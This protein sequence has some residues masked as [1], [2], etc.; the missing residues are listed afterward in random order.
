VFG[1]PVAREDD[2]L[3]AARAAL[4]LREELTALSDELDVELGIRIELHQ[5]LE[6][7]EVV[8]A[9]P[10]RRGALVTGD[11]VGLA[12][13]LQGSAAPGEIV[14]GPLAAS[15]I[16]HAGELEP[17]GELAVRGRREPV[18]ASRL[19]ALADAA[20]A[21]PRR[22]DVPLVGRRAELGALRE[23]LRVAVGGPSVEA[24]AVVGPAGIGKSRL[25]RELAAAAEDVAA[26]AARC[27]SHGKGMTYWPLRTLIEAA[28]SS[29]DR[30]AIAAVAD[31]STADV[32]AAAL[33]QDEAA[34]NTREVPWAFRRFCEALA[35]R[36]PVLLV[37]D[38]LHWAEPAFRDVVER[39]VEPGDAP[40][41]VVCLAREELLEERPDFVAG[42]RIALDALGPEETDR[43]VDQLV[44]NSPIPADVRAEVVAA[45]EGNPLFL[46]QL[47]AHV[48]ETGGMVA[49]PPTL[50]ALLAARLDRL[51]P[52][53]RA[54]L[55][56]AAVVGRNFAGRHVEALLDGASAVTARRHLQALAR[57][58]FLEPTEA[59]FEETFRFRHG[60]IRD[61]AYRATPKRERAALHE[62]YARLVDD[63][64]DELVGYHLE[65][66]VRLHDE[67]APRD[68]GTDALAAEAGERLGAAG[69]RVWKS[70]DAAGASR[71]LG[72]AT[73]L[74]PVE[75]PLRR[76]LMCE[77][78]VALDTAGEPLRADEVLAEAVEIAQLLHDRRIELRARIELTASQ[79]LTDRQD[80]AQELL[81]LVDE[82][83]RE[84]ESFEDHRALGRAWML[85]GW[86][87]GGVH[88][89]NKLWEESAERAL[90]HYR[91]A[92]FSVSTCLSQIA[93]ALYYG[94][95]PVMD[96]VRR[97]EALLRDEV[98][99]R[100][101]EANVRVYLGG[102]VAMRGEFER[103]GQL[104][105]LAR[106]TFRELGQPT[107]I[108]LTCAPISA[109][110]ALL[111]ADRTAAETDLH[112]ACAFLERARH[113]D[114][115]AMQAAQ[116]ADVL[117]L[118]ERVDEASS[119]LD[120]AMTHASGSRLSTEI[121]WRAVAARIR[122][123][124]G[125]LEEA[126]ELGRAAVALA[127][128]TDA[129]SRR[130]MTRCHLADVV[131]AIGDPGEARTLRSE[132]A[133]LVR[134][135]GIT[136]DQMELAIS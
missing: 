34:V 27:A 65:Q 123:T 96:A 39:L 71:L 72:R 115:L 31:D 69:I 66:A 43:L 79:L 51:G 47:V 105:R 68:R 117:Y 113:W 120:V 1:F 103:A 57:R 23:A 130:A 89:Q 125:R 104:V 97:C 8:A 42:R 135:K 131:D 46:E 67:L 49:V 26:L 129:L 30:D 101:A 48:A 78:G 111:A 102:L 41:L 37:L 109:A 112:E 36:R 62:R 11:A 54:V 58:G 59:A 20:D 95:T 40:M 5:A 53:E 4:A 32:L 28:V 85:A 92:G 50:R 24:V 94:P 91:R 33:G 82:A 12:S 126:L 122:L 93:A 134:A 100:A 118:G 9:G 108:A 99:D 13:R 35:R 128:R 45:A 73:A 16:A 86:V 61:A 121:A 75:G 74:L 63:G 76:E 88:G 80:R 124:E 70:H 110:V 98:H 3:R 133:A 87:H 25:A 81:A 60:L 114:D 119:W 84:L 18:R 19:I 22:L 90:V 44:G 83:L 2:A 64:P 15:L 132:A 38:D 17:L 52:G 7:G 6:S 10:S 106:T 116:L 127:D 29:V 56:R 55:E 136:V 107:A 21:V 14:V 77:L